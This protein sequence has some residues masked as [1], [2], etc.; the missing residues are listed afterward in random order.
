[1]TPTDI[2]SVWWNLLPEMGLKGDVDA[3]ERIGKDVVHVRMVD[4]KWGRKQRK[5]LFNQA[6]EVLHS[7]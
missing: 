4:M 6:I 3:M 2:T 7:F 5:W 1:M